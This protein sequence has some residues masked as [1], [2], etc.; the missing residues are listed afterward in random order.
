MKKHLTL[1]TT[2]L[3]AVLTASAQGEWKWAH[4]WSGGDGTYGAYYN[5]IT[6]TAFDE[7][8]NIYVYGSIGINPTIDGM[9]FQFINNGEVLSYNEKA[10]M[11]AKFD[12]LGNMLWHKVVKSSSSPS[13]PLWMEVQNDK[14]YVAGNSSMY[15]DRQDSWLYYMDYVPAV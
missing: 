8:G 12:T 4:Y 11:L 15:E 2:I 6:N 14:V 10:I 9:T 5:E 1:L 7:E 3:L 13:F